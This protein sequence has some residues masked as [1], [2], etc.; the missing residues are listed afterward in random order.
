MAHLRR[1]SF[2][3]YNAD[4]SV[5][6]KELVVLQATLTPNGENPSHVIYFSFSL[7]SVWIPGPR[8][9]A[10][11]RFCVCICTNASLVTLS[12]LS[13]FS[14]QAENLRNK[15]KFPSTYLVFK[16][17]PGEGGVSFVPPNKYGCRSMHEVKTSAFAETKILVLLIYRF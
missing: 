12:D 8:M 16:G 3:G 11:K 5:R 10:F 17:R 15:R 14:T 2:T 7:C 6:A 1:K 13:K 4:C 9:T